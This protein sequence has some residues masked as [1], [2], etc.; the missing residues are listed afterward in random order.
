MWE[1]NIVWCSCRGILTAPG[2]LWLAQQPALEA[3][4]TMGTRGDPPAV[5][6]EVAGQALSAGAPFLPP[7]SLCS[8]AQHPPHRQ[9]HW[10]QH[11][12]RNY[13]I[14][15]SVHFLSTILSQKNLFCVRYVS[16]LIL[17]LMLQFVG[18]F[19]Q[20]CWGFLFGFCFFKVKYITANKNN[21]KKNCIL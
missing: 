10:G 12:A 9:L 20:N 13:N 11:P 1:R 16:S 2:E 6:A 19:Q 15:Q 4:D 7:T 14:F 21:S 5:L 3:K 18:V 8:A 17:V